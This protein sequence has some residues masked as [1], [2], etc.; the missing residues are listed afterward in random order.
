MLINILMA[1][2]SCGSLKLNLI[3]CETNGQWG[4]RA[5][6][7]R[8]NAH[9]EITVSEE[10]YLWGNDLT[11][12]LQ[13]FL[14]AHKRDCNELKKLRVQMNSVLFIKKELIVYIKK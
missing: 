4:E 12:N 6:L 1:L 14:I 2:T 11:I 5:L 7:S 13:D 9:S 8:E 10:Y 3:G